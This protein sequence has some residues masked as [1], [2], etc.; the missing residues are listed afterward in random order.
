MAFGR[1]ESS[2]PKDLRRLS[3]DLRTALTPL[4]RGKTFAVFRA[5][6]EPPRSEHVKDCSAEGLDGSATSAAILVRHPAKHRGKHLMALLYCSPVSYYMG[7][8]LRYWTPDEQRELFQHYFDSAPTVCPVC[9]RNAR[10]RMHY[11]FELVLLSVCC[12][13]CENS[14]LL[15]FGG[16]IGLPAQTAYRQ[17]QKF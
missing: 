4:Q 1:Q 17:R 14:A 6:S 5:R 15:F 2:V 9:G 3:E 12:S 7:V 16:I 8:C 13:G 10:F 11:T